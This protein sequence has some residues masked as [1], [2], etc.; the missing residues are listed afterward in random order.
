MKCL[1]VYISD[2]LFLGS[3]YHMAIEEKTRKYIAHANNLFIAFVAILYMHFQNHRLV[4]LT[5]LVP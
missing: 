2:L 3:R 1:S 5:S 4:P